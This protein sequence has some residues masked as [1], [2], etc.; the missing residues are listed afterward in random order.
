MIRQKIKLR[1]GD[2]GVASA[3]LAAEIGCNKTVLSSFLRGKRGLNFRY[4]EKIFEILDLTLVP[5]ENFEFS[6]PEKASKSEENSAEN[7]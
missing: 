2:L 5:K 4:I 6:R 3:K 7:D 1:M